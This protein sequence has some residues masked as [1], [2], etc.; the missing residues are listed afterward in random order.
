MFV[1]KL[2]RMKGIEPFAQA[3]EARVLP[4][5]YTRMRRTCSFFKIS[6]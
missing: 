2:V 5:Y 1:K 6:A 3:W 4:L